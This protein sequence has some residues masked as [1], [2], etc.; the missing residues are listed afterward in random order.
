MQSSVEQRLKSVLLSVIKT[1]IDPDTVQSGVPLVRNGL[2]LDSVT[3]L[4]FILGIENEFNIMLDDGA[5]TPEH[6]ESLATL[7]LAVTVQIER[8][9]GDQSH[10]V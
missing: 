3:L 2:S 1:P 6:F 10:V 8:Q 7:A 5:L 9:S 4:E